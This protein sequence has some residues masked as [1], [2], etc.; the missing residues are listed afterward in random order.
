MA[1]G[2]EKLTDAG[3]IAAE[4]AVPRA[5]QI[6]EAL[7]QIELRKTGDPGEVARDKFLDESN[8][9]IWLVGM[10]MGPSSM[11]SEGAGF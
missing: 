2:K 9:R 5:R 11:R 6:V 3:V 10:F 7:T 1:V 4:F 8:E